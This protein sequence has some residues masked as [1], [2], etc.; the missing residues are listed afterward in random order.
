MKKILISF[1]VSCPIIAYADYS[2]YFNKC[3]DESTGITSEILDCIGL[4]IDYQD[5]RLNKAYKKLQQQLTKSE[6]F[7]LRDEQRAWIRT[8]DRNVNQ[9]YKTQDGTRADINGRSLY[10]ELTMKQANKLERRIK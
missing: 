4:E 8:R 5:D 3:S 7:K 9:I 10:L 2:T 1:L 6:K